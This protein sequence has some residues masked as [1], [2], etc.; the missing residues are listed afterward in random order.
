MITIV[1]V[2]YLWYLIFKLMRFIL[3]LPFN[4]IKWILN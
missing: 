1:A 4:T 3:L 2:W